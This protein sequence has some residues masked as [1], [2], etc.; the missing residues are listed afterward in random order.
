MILFLAL[1][2]V[3]LLA[4]LVKFKVIKL[5][6]WWKI[7]PLLWIIFLMFALFIPMQFWA[8]AGKALVLQRSISIVPNVSGQVIDV[9]VKP[10]TSIKK[11]DLLYQ[12]DPIPF[13]AARDQLKAQLDLARLSLNDARRL[14]KL[15][16]V[17]QSSLEQNQA[18]VKQLKAALVAADYNL[19]QTSVKAPSDGYVTNLALRTGAR[20]A[21]LPISQTM[22]FVESD[23]QVLSA[24]IPQGYLRLVKPGQEVEVTFILF[25]GKVYT[26]KV[27]TIVKANAAGQ[28]AISGNMIATRDL[29]AAPFVVHITLDDEELLHSLPAGAVASVAIY[30]TSGKPT[31]IIRKVMIRMESFM[32]FIKPF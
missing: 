19:A 27:K 9:P 20:V 26:G 18:Q 14:K 22:V 13:Q 4:A 12:I 31:H 28:A 5:N 8:P 25:P 17:S 10:N 23:E 24:Q 30:S 21:A 11:G 1:I 29:T 16:A 15:N 32:N 2:Y 7:S 6:L 3:G